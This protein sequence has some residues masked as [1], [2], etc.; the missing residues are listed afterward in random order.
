M[1]TRKNA[2]SRW[3]E[4]YSKASER[5]AEFSTMSGVPIKPLY[6]PEDAE[7]DYDEK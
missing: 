6:T 2:K 7:G 1:D 4:A 5:D 3:E